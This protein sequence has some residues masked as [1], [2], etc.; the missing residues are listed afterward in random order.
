MKEGNNGVVESLLSVEWMVSRREEE[1][2]G[3]NVGGRCGKGK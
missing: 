3:G 1:K 2:L